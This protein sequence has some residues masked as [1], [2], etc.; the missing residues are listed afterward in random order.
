MEKLA[1]GTA[2]PNDLEAMWPGA[3]PLPD[4]TRPLIGGGEFTQTLIINGDRV[5]AFVLIGASAGVQISFL[6]EGERGENGEDLSYF[7]ERP[8]TRA[9]DAVDLM[10]VVADE[11]ATGS[12]PEGAKLTSA[13]VPS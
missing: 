6:L 9:S 8:L 13:P 2:D 5:V 1:I 4:G 10:R 7:L 3:A 12:V 11:I